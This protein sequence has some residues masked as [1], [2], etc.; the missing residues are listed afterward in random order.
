MIDENTVITV[1]VFD[2]MYE[3]YNLESMT[4][5]Q[6]IDFWTEEG[7]PAPH[8]GHW[9]H[10]VWAAPLSDSTMDVYKCSEC[11]LHYQNNYNFC[12]NCGADMREDD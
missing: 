11:E 4:I 2:E 8:K 7:C 9:I 12:P 1:Q 3:E 10:E 6:A 5:R